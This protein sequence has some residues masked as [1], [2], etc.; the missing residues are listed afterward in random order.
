MPFVVL[1]SLQEY[2]YKELSI[3]YISHTVSS[4]FPTV[5]KRHCHL[6]I[7]GP[8][9]SSQPPSS[10]PENY[11]RESTFSNSGIR[12][13]PGQIIINPQPTSDYVPAWW[14]AVRT[15]ALL[16]CGGHVIPYS[17]TPLQ[18]SEGAITEWLDSC[19]FNPLLWEIK[20]Y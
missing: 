20:F 4:L 2:S 10:L 9:D 19:F 17:F 14:L 13:N 6:P 18:Q 11:S 3:F 8:P 5:L 1:G 15:Q 12:V 16:H 7:K